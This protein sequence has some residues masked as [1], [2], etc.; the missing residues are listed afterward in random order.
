MGSLLEK[1]LLQAKLPDFLNSISQIQDRVAFPDGSPMCDGIRFFTSRGNATV[2]V[3]EFEPQVRAVHWIDTDCLKPFGE[4]SRYRKVRLSFPYMVMVVLFVE[5]RLSGSQQLF[6]RREPISTDQ[7]LLD[8]PNL[9]NTAKG[10]GNLCWLCLAQM[11]HVGALSWNKKIEAVVQHFW[12]AGFNLSSEYHEGM[13]YFQ[14]MKDLDPRLKSIAEWEKATQE[15]PLFMIKIPWKSTGMTIREVIDSML[16]KVCAPKKGQTASSLFSQMCKDA[17]S[18]GSTR[19]E[20]YLG[21]LKSFIGNF[22]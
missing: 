4:G 11:S 12:E 21:I 6:Y 18:K 14:K 17:S 13:S 9:L 22:L 19:N 3:I 8:Y 10:Y 2:A 5:G 16:G 20:K 15:D 7:D 1:V